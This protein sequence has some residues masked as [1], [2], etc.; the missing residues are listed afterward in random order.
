MAF[1]KSNRIQKFFNA[2]KYGNYI[3]LT[4]NP[5][6]PAL[7]RIAFFSAP[8]QK[9]H[10]YTVD[11][12]LRALGTAGGLISLIYYAFQF[13]LKSYQLH[14]SDLQIAQDLNLNKELQIPSM[15]KST[16][17][18]GFLKLYLLRKNS[19]LAWIFSCCCRTP[20][21]K[22]QN[23]ATQKYVTDARKLEKVCSVIESQFDLQKIHQSIAD[24]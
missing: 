16:S 10:T 3:F 11:T 12:Y 17:T 8:Q 23:P 13:L 6:N 1:F 19:I 5:T 22:S 24:L 21:E 7:G 18:C 20:K 2:K 4:E 9:V 15:K 14:F